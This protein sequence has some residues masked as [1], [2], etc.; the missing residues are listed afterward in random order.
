[1]YV[2]DPRDRYDDLIEELNEEEIDA[3]AFHALAGSEAFTGGW[4][5]V[6]VVRHEGDV[7]LAYHADDGAW[8][9][10]GGSVK[11]GE[12]LREAVVREVREETGVEVVPDRPHAVVEHVVTHGSDSRTFRLVVFSARPETAE[13][14]TDLGEP[15]EP[16]EDA[17]WF[18]E[19]PEAVFEREFAE[20]LLDRLGSDGN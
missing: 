10:P 14:G 8:L 6:A 13:I 16:I 19:L 18:A 4:V 7:L 12:S 11:P 2:T 17:G 3:E 15:G 9:L 1:M 5:A 20:R